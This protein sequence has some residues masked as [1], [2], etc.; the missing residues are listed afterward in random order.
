MKDLAPGYRLE[1]EES[2]ENHW[3]GTCRDV[4][5]VF[6][7]EGSH[8]DV[9]HVHT[10]GRVLERLS[11]QTGAP[12][13]LL[14]VLPPQ[15]SKPPDGRVRDALAQGVRRLEKQVSRAAVVVSGTGFGAALHRGAVTGILALIRSKTPVKVVGD[16]RDGLAHL[17]E[18]DCGAFQPLLRHC[19]ERVL[20]PI[21]NST[22]SDQKARGTAGTGGA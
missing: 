7:Y 2:T 5:L 19:E 18:A 1:L 22:A 3:I 17:M 13:K 16:V 9:R 10:T 14:F 21:E 20:G 12:V 15:H 6:A 8:D 4:V 11:R